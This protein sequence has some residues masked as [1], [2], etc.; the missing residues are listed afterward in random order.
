[1]LGDKLTPPLRLALLARSVSR[2][3]CAGGPPLDEDPSLCGA[4]A[5]VSALPITII[6]KQFAFQPADRAVD[7]LEFAR[8]GVRARRTVLG[9]PTDRI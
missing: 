8:E 1:M 2:S 7:L 6:P 9:P 3:A 4:L 5:T